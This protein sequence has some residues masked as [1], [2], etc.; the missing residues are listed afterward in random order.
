MTTEDKMTIDDRGDAGDVEVTPF[1]W[2][3][4][5]AGKAGI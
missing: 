4:F 5:W 1:D 3:R 2:R